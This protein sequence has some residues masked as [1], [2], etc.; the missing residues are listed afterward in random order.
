MFFNFFVLPSFISE[1]NLK[2]GILVDFL[3][4]P[5]MWFLCC[6]VVGQLQADTSPGRSTEL[7]AGTNS[8]VGQFFKE[9]NGFG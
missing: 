5:E 8:K 7:S 1:Q 3:V 2:I 6:R 9:V 4:A